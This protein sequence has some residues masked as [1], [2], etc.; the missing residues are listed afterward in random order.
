MLKQLLIFGMGVY[1]GLWIDQNYEI[2]KVDQVG[3]LWER[4]KEYAEANKKDRSKDK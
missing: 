4:L 1:T 2:P 3:V